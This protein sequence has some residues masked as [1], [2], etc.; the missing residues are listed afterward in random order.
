MRDALAEK[1]RVGS[2]A[3]SPPLMR[4]SCEG[5]NF[6][7]AGALLNVGMKMK[8]LALAVGVLLASAS[9]AF[10]LDPTSLVTHNL[11][12]LGQA[13]IQGVNVTAGI[14]NTGV[15]NTANPATASSNFSATSSNVTGSVNSTITNGV[16]NGT[17]AGS[18][19]VDVISSA[20]TTAGLTGVG[21]TTATATGEGIGFAGGQSIYTISSVGTVTPVLP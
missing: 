18:G 5:A 10:A 8:K 9:S 17:G 6:R 21:S 16:F 20:S 14:V 15:L 3:C 7:N 12:A 1:R 2:L 4:G 13:G 11:S 19:S